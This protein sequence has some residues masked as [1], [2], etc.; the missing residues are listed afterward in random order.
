MK[1]LM[2]FKDIKLIAKVIENGK[3]Q[4]YYQII[5]SNGKDLLINDDLFQ[6][7]KKVE[8]AA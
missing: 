3:E 2:M 8:V 5:L 6:A 7:L 1:K 4:F